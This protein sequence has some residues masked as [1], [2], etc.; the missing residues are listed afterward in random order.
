MAPALCGF[1]VEKEQTGMYSE[2][3]SCTLQNEF[4]GKL[5]YL[6]TNRRLLALRPQFPTESPDVIC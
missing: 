3:F 5:L 2:F 6:E 1:E 4:I